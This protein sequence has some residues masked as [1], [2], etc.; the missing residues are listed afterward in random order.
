MSKVDRLI[1]QVS[2]LR[3]EELD[4]L[5]AR[6]DALRQDRLDLDEHQMAGLRLALIEGEQSGPP[7]PFDI[8]A[9]IAEKR[10]VSAK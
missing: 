9:F 4:E 3:P 1:E 2:A 10:R 5:R 7:Q 8:E 6:L